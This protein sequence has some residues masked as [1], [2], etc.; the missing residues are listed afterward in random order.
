MK[1]SKELKRKL[2][3]VLWITAVWTIISM[4]QLGYE[5]TIIKEYGLEYRWSNSD[6]FITYFLINTAAFISFGLLYGIVIY[7]VFFFLM[8]CLQNYFVIRSIWDGGTPFFQA[9]LKGLKD[10][11]ISYEFIRLFPFWLLILTGTLITLFINDKYG[12]GELKKFLLGK[13]F[14]PKDERRFFMF[15]DLKGST[16]IAEKLGEHQYFSFIQK[17]FKDVTPVLLDTE[18][19]VYQYVGDEMVLTWKVKKGIRDLNCIRCF[20]GIR[21]LLD[22]LAP[23]YMEQFGVI[24]EFKAG[25]HV[26]AAVV[27]EI[28]VIKR[29]IAYSGDVLNTTARI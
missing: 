13:Y 6:G 14:H 20:Q 24:P 8:T 25:L 22:E 11:F 2:Q 27:G 26:G 17:V 9:Y 28:G 5:I 3:T 29:D 18:G 23:V 19:E 1:I 10:Y 15:L 7:V 12:P 16:G 21:H 4:M